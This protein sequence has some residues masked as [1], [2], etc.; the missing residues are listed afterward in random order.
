MTHTIATS[1]LVTLPVLTPTLVASVRRIR[2]RLDDAISALQ[3]ESADWKEILQD[4]RDD[5][6]E[7]GESII[8]NEIDRVL[9][10]A[11]S[12]A[13]LNKM[14]FSDFI[15]DR[16]R[17][18][19]IRIKA[20]IT[21]E[22]IELTP[23]FCKPSPEIIDMNLEPRRRNHIKFYG[24]NLDVANVR[25]FL[26]EENNKREVTRHMA[27]PSEY[28]ITLNLGDNGVE[29]TQRSNKLVFHLGNE[30]RTINII[31]PI[32]E[33]YRSTL[34]LTGKI[35]MKDMRIGRDETRT[36]DLDEEF[37]LT[38][39]KRQREYKNY[40]CCGSGRKVKGRMDIEFNLDPDE[41]RV[42]GQGVL[43]YHE[44][45]GICRSINNERRSNTFSFR[46]GA[47]DRWQYE[48]KL[49]DGR[50]YVDFAFTLFNEASLIQI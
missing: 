31:Q 30:L 12:D 29:L 14:C 42:Y 1:T 35:R 43:E 15:L 5:F 22:E 17:T 48:K 7:W 36:V 11:I 33:K 45:G 10:E 34:R 39:D 41:G 21:G 37:F 44:G 26:V 28:L 49:T 2:A 18:A 19:L 4:T 6:L 9:S 40:W 13:F 20:R 50:D 38:P 27:V 47:G 24:Y 25:V 32:V 16:T 23:V 46:V 8:A 3:N